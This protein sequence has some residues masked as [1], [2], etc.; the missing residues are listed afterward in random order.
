ML[1][2]SIDQGPPSKDRDSRVDVPERR[3][4]LHAQWAKP[5]LQDRRSDRGMIFWMEP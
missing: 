1:A 4:V 2:P 3:R 5:P